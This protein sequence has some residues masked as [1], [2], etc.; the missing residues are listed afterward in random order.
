MVPPHSDVQLGGFVMNGLLI[1]TTAAFLLLLSQFNNA[2]A[3]GPYD[4]EW[5]GT[6]TSAG[7]RC[8]R[9]VVKLTVDG[10][11]V[12]GQARFERDA[13]NINGTVD[14]DGVFGATI[15]F[16]PFR[17]QFVSDAFEGTFK[18]FDCEWKAL[19]RRTR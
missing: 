13:P 4:G 2:D 12:L 5:T 7:E 1:V 6:A 16:Q 17:G 10:H 15:G 3:A 9:A 18:S 8:K 19:L 14:G 11:V